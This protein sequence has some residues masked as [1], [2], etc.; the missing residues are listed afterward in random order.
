[1]SEQVDLLSS[2]VR[3]RLGEGALTEARASVLQS[4]LQDL[5]GVSGA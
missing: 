4:R 1:V 2:K 5:R 3:Q